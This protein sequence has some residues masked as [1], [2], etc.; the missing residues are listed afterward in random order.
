[1][2]FRPAHWA[3]APQI[4]AHCRSFVAYSTGASS[5]VLTGSE[6]DASNV[7]P[8]VLPELQYRGVIAVVLGDYHKVRALPTCARGVS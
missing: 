7:E 4:S 8:R 1:M 6:S 3:D 5:L 2:N